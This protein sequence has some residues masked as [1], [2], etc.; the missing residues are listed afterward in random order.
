M[1]R[2]T[3]L[4]G[5]VVSPWLIAVSSGTRC[6]AM[7][8]ARYP[9]Q[10]MGRR[11]G[12]MLAVGFV[13]LTRVAGAQSPD[14]LAAAR[15]VF[16]E[17]L[18]DEEHQRFGE[19]L[20]KYKRVLQVRE[21]ASV[22]YRMGLT[23]EGLGRLNEAIDAHSAAVRLGGASPKDAEVARAAKA[24]IDALE[25]R[26]A[27]LALQ[28]PPSPAGIEVRVDDAA[29]PLDRTGDVR[30]DPGPH[31]V[32]ATA[33]GS[34]PFKAQVTLSDG[35]RAAIPITLQAE[36]PPPP[37]PPPPA[38]R[39]S[40]LSTVGLI[41]GGAGAV[42][43][44]GGG[45]V[46]A[47]RASAILG[48][49]RGLPERPL[50]EPGPGVDP[51]D[52]RPRGHGDDGWRG[53]AHDRSGRA[54]DGDSPLLARQARDDDRAIL[55]PWRARDLRRRGSL[56][57]TK[58]GGAWTIFGLACAAVLAFAACAAVPDLNFY[59]DKNTGP[60]SAV[61]DGAST[62]GASSSSGGS[63][64]AGTDTGVPTGTCPE[65]KPAGA[66]ACCG[67]A[68]CVGNGCNSPKKCDSCPVGCKGPSFVCC[69][70]TGSTV[71]CKAASSCP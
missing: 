68:W 37:P 17:A 6:S 26:V 14:E 44:V 31:V 63:P 1:I 65:P 13:L 34:Q 5:A 8:V 24:R 43:L 70:G 67:A 4:D 71:D 21:T 38:P 27:H 41:A 3:K 46:M 35:G 56:L 2:G 20:E 32:T 10:R 55:E 60:D 29:V 22:R 23:L 40:S 66:L 15:Q 7:A 64:E 51:E 62:D 47:M 42:L 33:P 69:A 53:P 9:S 61:P 11:L 36:A 25:P 16:A 59:D 45:V 50:P 19:A 58:R 18:A 39:S 28:V 49:P 52:P 12:G 57:I 48:S 54:R 30:L